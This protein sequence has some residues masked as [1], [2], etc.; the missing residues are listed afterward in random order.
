MDLLPIKLELESTQYDS[1]QLTMT[2]IVLTQYNTSNTYKNIYVGTIILISNK[3]CYFFCHLIDYEKIS[4]N[5]HA[6]Q[7]QIFV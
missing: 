6:L 7:N 5:C 2:F 3:L 4:N 1:L